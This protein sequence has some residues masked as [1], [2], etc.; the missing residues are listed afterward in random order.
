MWLIHT[1]TF[2]ICTGGRTKSSWI[3]W[4]GRILAIF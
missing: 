3:G 1:L 4:R 2:L